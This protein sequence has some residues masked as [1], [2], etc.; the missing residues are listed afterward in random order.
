MS[1]V[2]QGPDWW[3][4]S[5]GKW[6]PPQ[7]A[8]NP[9]TP[10]PGQVIGAQPVYVQIAGPKN[11]GM[12]VAG[13]VCGIASIPLLIACGIGLIL[14]ILGLVFGIVGMKR[15][16]RSNGALVGRSMGMAGAICG[17]ISVGLFTLY[18]AGVLIA[19]AT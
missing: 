15:I 11:D 16:D 7:S 9:P 4:A 6:Y 5:D 1:D 14:G 17:G 10:P 2:S 19:S 3:I 18:L 12:A 8:M 13:L